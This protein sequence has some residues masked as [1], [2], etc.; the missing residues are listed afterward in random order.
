M[1]HVLHNKILL[2]VVRCVLRNNHAFTLIELLVVI[3]ILGGLSALIVPNFMEARKDARDAQRKNDM[4]QVQ[5]AL[6]LYKLDQ[7]PVAYPTALPTPGTQWTNG[8]TT[9]YMSKF[10]ADPTSTAHYKYTLNNSLSYSFCACLENAADSQGVAC[11]A[12][13][14]TC[15]SNKCYIVT[16]P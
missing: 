1:K 15:T 13:C 10:P 16:E 12:S 5:R 8:G 2:R 3:A 4:K 9:V 11:G 7:N 6:E 14:N